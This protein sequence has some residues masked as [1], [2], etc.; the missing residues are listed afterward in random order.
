[1]K[2]GLILNDGG[3]SI[4]GKMQ[5]EHSRRWKN[6]LQIHSYA[7]GIGQT[8]GGIDFFQVNL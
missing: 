4:S 7:D 5:E 1:M 2:N 6:L 3:V 8:A